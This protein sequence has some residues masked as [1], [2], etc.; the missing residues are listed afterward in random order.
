LLSEERIEKLNRIKFI[1]NTYEYRWSIG[2]EA[3]KVY[4]NKEGHC[5]IPAKHITDNDYDLG[6]WASDQRTYNNKN[7]LSK[8]RLNKLKSIGFDFDPLATKWMINYNKFKESDFK[9]K[10]FFQWSSSVR[11]M[12]SKGNLT[13]EQVELI[14][15]IEGWSWGLDDDWRDFIGYVKEYKDS[16]G[17]TL[18]PQHYR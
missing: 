3:A 13:D 14:N 17:D 11:E 10:S 7:L 16:N 5:S 2:F 15:S 8:D 6:Y 18:V 12:N 4:K 1:W 9:T